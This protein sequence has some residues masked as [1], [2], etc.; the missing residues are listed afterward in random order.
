MAAAEEDTAAPSL[1]E[2]SSKGQSVS[3]V[4]GNIITSL[5]HGLHVR[6]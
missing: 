5:L 6:V 4:L 1:A 3:P 2:P